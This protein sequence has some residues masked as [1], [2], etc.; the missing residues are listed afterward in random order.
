MF[1]RL[2]D[3]DEDDFAGGAGAVSVGGDEVADV[4]DLVGDADASGEEHDGAVGG[5]VL[6]AVG[7]LDPGVCGEFSCRAGFG[8]GEHAV[9]EAGAAAHD[10]GH[11]ADFA[12]E[13]VLPGHGEGA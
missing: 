7:A 3:P 4:G 6:G 8:F 13:D 5:E 2:Y 1:G 12:G 10:E 11:G 9:G